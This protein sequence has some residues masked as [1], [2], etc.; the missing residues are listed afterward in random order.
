MIDQCVSQTR[1]L[2][3]LASAL[4]PLIGMAY[5]TGTHHVQI[6][7]DQALDEM[8]VGLHGRCMAPIRSLRSSIEHIAPSSLRL[9]RTNQDP[10]L[11]RVKFTGIH[12]YFTQSITGAVKANLGGI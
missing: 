2:D 6:H 11:V 9:P 3:L 7:I 8:L 1:L 4:I 5:N 10:S 12:E